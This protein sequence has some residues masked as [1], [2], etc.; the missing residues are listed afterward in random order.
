MKTIWNILAVL[1]L[2]NILAVAG[3]LL[4]LKSS[5][6]LSKERVVAV[7]ERFIKTVAQEMSEKQA[8]DIA[9]RQKEAD[10]AA[11]EKMAIPPST[12]AEKIA[13]QQLK[14]DQ[15]SQMLLRQQQIVENMQASVMLQ[16]AKLEEREKKLEEDRRAFAAERKKIAETEG[17]KQFQVALTTLEGQKAKDAKKVLRALLDQKLSDQVVAYLAKMEEGKR[18]KVM[19]EFVKDEPSMAAELLERLRTRGIVVPPSGSLAQASA[20][21]STARPA[22]NSPLDAAGAQ[23]A[24]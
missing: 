24:R 20:Y 18:S 7:R 6:R 3:G 2:I 4:W 16:L 15:R 13:D 19:A 14:D 1:A 12:A 9:A 8:A 10:A 22:T 5:D 11:A 17:D 23:P 21:E